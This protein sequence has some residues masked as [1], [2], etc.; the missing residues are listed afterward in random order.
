MAVLAGLVGSRLP[1]G[2]I[3]QEDQGYMSVNVQLPA[4]A[5]MQRT[6]AVCNQIDAI[7]K[8]TPGVQNYYDVPPGSDMKVEGHFIKVPRNIA[9]GLNAYGS[10][11]T[12][13]DVGFPA[14]P[15]DGSWQLDH[16]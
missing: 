8:D 11:I 2:F 4:S 10:D 15:T 12:S 16:K 6:G 3:P 7:L 1:A 14:P 9:T 5:S 13:A